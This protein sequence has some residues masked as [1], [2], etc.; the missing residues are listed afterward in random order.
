MISSM[1]FGRIGVVDIGRFRIGQPQSNWLF[2]DSRMLVDFVGRYKTLNDDFSHVCRII[3]I[4]PSSL[5]KLNPTDRGDY[6]SFYNDETAN[7]IG[8][9]YADDIRNFGFSFDDGARRET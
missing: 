6:R 9:V 3:G 7:I 8:K 5:P 1:H 2:D 4:V